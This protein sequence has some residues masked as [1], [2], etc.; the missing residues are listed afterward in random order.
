[1]LARL[2]IRNLGLIEEAEMAFHPG[3]NVITGET[4]AGKSLILDSL[5]LLSGRRMERLTG[6]DPQ[7]KSLLEAVFSEPLVEP[8]WYEQW[9]VDAF[10]DL[11]LR[12]EFSPDGRSRHFVNDTPVPVQGLKELAPYLFDVHSQFD[13]QRLAD[14]SYRLLL[15]DKLAGEEGTALD[16]KKKYSEILKTS[17]DLET[18]RKKQ[19]EALAQEDFLRFRLEELRKAAIQPDEEIRLEEERQRLAHAESIL[20]YCGQALEL[21][22]AEEQ[23]IQAL[24]S[25]LLALMRKLAGLVKEGQALEETAKNLLDML[26]HLENQVLRLKDKTELSPQRLEEVNERLDLL[27]SLMKKNQVSSAEALLEKQVNLERTLASMMQDTEALEQ[28]EKKLEADRKALLN[29][30]GT[31]SQARQNAAQKLSEKMTHLL[32]EL[33]LDRAQFKVALNVLEE[34]GPIGLDTCDF[35]FSAHPGSPLRPLQKVASGGELSRVMLALK[36]VEAQQKMA[37][38][39]VLDEID[40]G[41]SGRVSGMTAHFLRRLAKDVQIIA[42]THLPQI[43]AAGSRHFLVEKTV[44]SEKKTLSRVREIKG[45]TRQEVLA[46]MLSAGEV[47]PPSLEAAKALLDTFSPAVA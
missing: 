28:A 31:L 47:G 24:L 12:R 27:N 34:L 20:L 30:A 18:R 22:A 26:Q 19:E 10:P 45:S 21:M 44:H 9:Q 4:G 11:I 17:K 43:A 32:S 46:S 13:T 35:L 39:L 5:A 25:R 37:S 15:L 7:N 2:L 38:T 29:I 23:G 36:A 33:A 8:S 16:Y 40:A 1:M 14:N 42:V 6:P 3:L 41:I